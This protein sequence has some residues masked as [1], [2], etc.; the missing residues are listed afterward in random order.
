MTQ[1][2]RL[3]YAPD[4]ASLIIRLALEELGLPYEAV[5]V[6]RSARAQESAAYRAINP[7]GLI[8]AIEIEHGAIFETAA[9]LLWL[10][11][12][13]PGT[14]APLPG[15]ARRGDFLK[16][17]VFLSNTLH[18]ALRVNFYTEKYIRPAPELIRE[19]RAA[20]R[21]DVVRHLDTLEAHADGGVFGGDAPTLIDLYLAPMLRWLAL[22]PAG[23]ADWFDLERWPRLRN[24]CLGLEGRPAVARVQAAEGLGP[25]PFTAPRPPTP[26]EGSAT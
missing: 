3:H 6:D 26:P 4:N 9:I 2:L 22:Y 7:N 18:A 15:S 20:C 1:L 17:L 5:L 8:P 23:D 10:D 19:L 24:I 16:W 14:L 11:E 25:T 21:R 13:L 12:A